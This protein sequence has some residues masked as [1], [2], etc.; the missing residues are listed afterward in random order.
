M[1]SNRSTACERRA[2][3]VA[4]RI[5]DEARSRTTIEPG[6]AEF[7]ADVTR[8]VVLVH[9]SV[10]PVLTRSVT[11]LVREFHAAGYFVVLSSACESPDALVWPE[12]GMPDDTIVVRKPNI[13][14]DFGTAAVALDFFPGIRSAEHVLIVN[15]SNVGPLASLR[16]VIDHFE[17]TTADAWALTGSNQHGFHLQS[18]FLG[19]TR[20]VLLERPL[21]DFWRDIRHFDDK[22]KVILHYELG[23]S[24]LLVQEGY[25]VEVMF[26]HTMFDSAG[27]ANLSANL[28]LDLIGQDYPFVKREV[29]QKPW[30]EESAVL[31]PGVARDFYREDVASWL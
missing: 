1:P 15:D 6:S 19:F 27:N 4:R 7:P 25:I 23:L 12:G 17:A 10:S 26:P 30:I 22:R 21:S 8:C 9:F 13:G 16:T 29:L 18:F 31:I 3:A 28:W 5:V 14:Y 11:E 2:D 20:R 24:R